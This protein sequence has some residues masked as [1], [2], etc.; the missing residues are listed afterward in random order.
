M[1]RL[2]VVLGAACAFLMVGMGAASAQSEYDDQAR[3]YLEAGM[4]AHAALGY[5]RD[6]SVADLVAPLR[7]EHPKI[8]AVRLRQ[9]VNYRVYGACDND[10][11]DIDMEIY[12]ANGELADRDVA[13]D[14][15][16]Y[17][18]ITPSQTGLHF[19]RLWVF[20]CESEPCYAAARVV[21][22]G[23]PAERIVAEEPTGEGPDYVDVV[24]AELEDAGAAHLAAGYQA[25]GA[26]FI[27][28]IDT[29][30]DGYRQSFSLAAG[31]AYLFQGACD[32]DCSDVD[33]EVLGPNGASL[34]QDVATDDRPVVAFTA[35]RAGEYTV[36]VWLAQCSVEPCYV[37]LRGYSR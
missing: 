36:R 11:S 15:T 33:L 20:A 34:G 2:A 37:G 14:D 32:Q 6:N 28:A 18:Q 19:V 21:S 26:D 22:G 7:L 31:R 35:P 13:T 10:C 16:P 27:E 23:T 30:G 29:T 8:W 17:V 25:L 3:S 9:G 5:R 12:D 1:K 24:R 4:D